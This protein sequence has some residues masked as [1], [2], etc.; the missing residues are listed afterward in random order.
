MSLTLT[1]SKPVTE[2][3]Y[4]RAECLKLADDDVESVTDSLENS[5][6]LIGHSG[7][8]LLTSDLTPPKHNW[9]QYR[10]ECTFG[11]E[12]II[13]ASG[14]IVKLNVDELHI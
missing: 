13:T 8:S 4:L 11:G 10:S 9:A 5:W 1:L 2:G 3:S 7:N 12:C 6:C 14:P